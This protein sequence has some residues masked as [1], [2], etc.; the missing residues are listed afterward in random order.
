M[1]RAARLREG[2]LTEPA[3]RDRGRAAVAERAWRCHLGGGAPS[4]A[5]RCAVRAAAQPEQPG[6][7]VEDEESA[8]FGGRQPGDESGGVAPR[9]PALTQDRQTA[10]TTAEWR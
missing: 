2:L 7:V 6:Q 9:P 1:R 10:L 4:A 3:G 8:A 5:H